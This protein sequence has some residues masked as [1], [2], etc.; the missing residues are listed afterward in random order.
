MWISID[1]FGRGLIM[2]IWNSHTSIG[3]IV[4]N[5][6]AAV[7]VEVNAGFLFSLVIRTTGGCPSSFL[8]SS[9]LLSVS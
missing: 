5:T 7:F 9:C 2:G 3:N 4:G 1:S 6:I 8:G